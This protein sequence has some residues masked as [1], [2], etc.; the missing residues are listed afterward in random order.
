L[1]SAAAQGDPDI[2][3]NVWDRV[4][5]NLRSAMTAADYH[6]LVLMSWLLRDQD[7]PCLAVVATFTLE[8]HLADALLTLAEIRWDPRAAS[9]ATVDAMLA[10][11]DLRVFEVVSSRGREMWTKAVVGVKDGPS[12]E[13]LLTHYPADAPE[14]LVHFA[15]LVVSGHDVTQ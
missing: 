2:V 9:G 11:S 5:A 10:W 12:R 14:A 7:T 15:G 8:R 3:G 13:A 4:P 6:Q 1:Q